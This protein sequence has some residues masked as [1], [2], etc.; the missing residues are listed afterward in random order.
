[1]TTLSYAHGTCAEPLLADTIGLNLERTVAR[2]PDHE[3][4]VSCHQ[5]LRYTYAELGNAVDRL[6]TGMLEGGLRKG[7]RVGVWSPNRAEWVLVQYA[8][9]KIGVTSG[10]SESCISSLR[11]RSRPQG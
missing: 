8:T 4:L 9:A 1:M 5:G 2:F 10:V 7:D 3:A 11:S 6:A